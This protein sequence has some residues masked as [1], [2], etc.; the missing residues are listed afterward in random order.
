[1]YIDV[2]LGMPIGKPT[3]NGRTYPQVVWDN[4]LKNY[5]HGIERGN[6]LK[7]VYIH[8]ADADVVPTLDSIAGFITKYDDGIFTI[9][10]IDSLAGSTMQSMIPHV[11]DPI[12]IVPF[13]V[14]KISMDGTVTEYKILKFYIPHLT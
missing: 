4:A 12:Q 6:A 10:L 5:L 13:G 14:G 1:M 2:V 3:Q 8:D 9:K 7:R 11:V